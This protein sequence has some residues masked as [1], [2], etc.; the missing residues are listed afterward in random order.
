MYIYSLPLR[1]KHL[2][3]KHPGNCH[4]W[5]LIP[6]KLK[7]LPHIWPYKRLNLGLDVI[8]YNRISYLH[9]LDSS[10][11]CLYGNRR[12]K[13]NADPSSPGYGHTTSRNDDRES[14]KEMSFPKTLSCPQLVSCLPVSCHQHPSV[15][16]N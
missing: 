5:V 15:A 12:T 11:Y 6:T 16:H 1:P 4:L 7:R 3:V 14:G 10:Y 2:H 9:G 13:I 8:A